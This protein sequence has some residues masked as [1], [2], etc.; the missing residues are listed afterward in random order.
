MR[1][2][3]QHIQRLESGE[4][5]LHK[6][7]NRLIK[8]AFLAKKDKQWQ[9]IL[10]LLVVS[11]EL[12]C[13]ADPP[14]HKIAEMSRSIG[15]CS[16]LDPKIILQMDDFKTFL[17]EKKVLLNTSYE[18]KKSE[19]EA[20]D[21]MI[22]TAWQKYEQSDEKDEDDDIELLNSFFKGILLFH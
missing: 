21:K 20:V 14:R 2:F 8:D 9:T 12:C 4:D 15:V 17:K 1:D 5:Q 10:K 18:E 3:L 6:L 11:G 16:P 22:F 19:R 13:A 7:L